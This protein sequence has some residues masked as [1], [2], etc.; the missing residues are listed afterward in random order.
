MVAFG[1]TTYD[2]LSQLL[3]NSLTDSYCA[4]YLDE[5]LGNMGI[6]GVTDI[7]ALTTA[8]TTA[9]P[10]LPP[11]AISDDILSNI[12]SLENLDFSTISSI[13]SNKIN[14]IIL[15]N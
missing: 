2:S 3:L 12:T 13:L 6:Q 5:L 15:E 7:S 4:A 14:K 10:F 11:D 1:I 8:A 9:N